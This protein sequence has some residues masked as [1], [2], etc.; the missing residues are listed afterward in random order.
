MA[1]YKRNQIEEAISAVLDPQ[2]G[3]RTAELRTQLKRLLDTDRAGG[4]QSG[5]RNPARRYRSIVPSHREPGWKS[6][7]RFTKLSHF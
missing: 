3:K 1:E 7:F 2:S 4:R 6:G 5:S